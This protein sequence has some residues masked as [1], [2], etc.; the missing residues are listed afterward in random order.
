MD[1]LKYYYIRYLFS[2]DP[3]KT[4]LY[5]S[6]KSMF[7]TVLAI[8]IAMIEMTI[9]SVWIILPCFLVMLMLNVQLPFRQRMRQ[10]VLMWLAC[11]VPVLIMLLANQHES[12]RIVIFLA[13]ALAASFAVSKA[14]DVLKIG[15][16]ATIFALL[17]M[18]FQVSFV[19]IKI[20]SVNFSLSLLL[21]FVTNY[22]IFPNKL[23][24]QIRSSLTAG[25]RMLG[26]YY[27]FLLSDA[28][29]GNHDSLRRSQLQQQA[30]AVLEY[31]KKITAAY[32]QVHPKSPFV[33]T[34]KTLQQLIYNAVSVEAAISRLTVRAYFN[35]PLSELQHYND[36][37]RTLFISARKKD[38]TAIKHLAGEHK[39][40]L[41]AISSQN[42]NLQGRVSSLSHDYQQWYQ[43]AFCMG[44]FDVEL[45]HY[46][47]ILQEH[48]DAG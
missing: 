7:V 23:P 48:C 9:H 17:G 8:C 11:V 31:L 18:R 2:Y 13:I 12:I 28:A 33:A 24:S 4:W 22:F 3:S 16:L 20:I 19:N 10:V 42:K 34:T 40:L 47:D 38:Y 1:Y 39:K 46:I 32:Q 44:R 45:Q 5:H 29:V 26:Q 35:G 37:Y 15:I 43:V 27:G 14:P 41:L 6:I 36:V 25:F 30:V 21:L